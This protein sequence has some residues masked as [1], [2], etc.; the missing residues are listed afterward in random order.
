MFVNVPLHLCVRM[1]LS[2]SVYLYVCHVT[3]TGMGVHND[4]TAGRETKP[5][6]E[7]LQKGRRLCCAD[8]K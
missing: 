5:G 4:L 1:Y 7:G 2:M 3:I 6:K 8:A